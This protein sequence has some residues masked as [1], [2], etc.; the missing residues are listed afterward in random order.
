[1]IALKNV[2]IRKN[3]LKI[4]VFSANT[5]ILVYFLLNEMFGYLEM[6]AGEFLIGYLKFLFGFIQ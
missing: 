6:P 5:L 3:T 2:D 1:M 4:L